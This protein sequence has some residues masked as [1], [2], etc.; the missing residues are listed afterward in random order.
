M[1]V[2]ARF[3]KLKNDT[4]GTPPPESGRSRALK[5]LRSSFDKRTQ[6]LGIWLFLLC[7]VG[8]LGIVFLLQMVL[9]VQAGRI[10]NKPEAV[11]VEQSDGTGFLVDAIPSSQ[12]TPRALQRFTADILTALFAV[13]P[14]VEPAGEPF[15][16]AQVHAGIRVPKDGTPERGNDRVTANAYVAA[17]A[18]ISPDFRDAFL[19]KL[20]A[21]TPAGAFNGSTQVLFKLDYLGEP[22]PVEGKPGQ[23]TITAIGA[24][25]IVEG[26]KTAGTTA[27]SLQ[28]EAFRQVVYL[29]SVAPQFDPLEEI[30]T[31]L[32]KAVF[33]IA[34]TGLRIVKMVPLDTTAPQG[35]DFLELPAQPANPEDSTSRKR[36]K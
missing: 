16:K 19:A 9:L 4:P 25:Y 28:P 17:V 20:A 5:R 31:D 11:L 1:Q 2:I 27:T 3:K 8:A 13:S 15:E 36:S 6:V 26:G 29:E 35:G 23:W 18:A 7:N 22:R 10:A 32:Q 30:S 33:S 12:R 24:R 34:R 14:I 21:L